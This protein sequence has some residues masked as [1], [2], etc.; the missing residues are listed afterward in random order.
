MQKLRT[1]TRELSA[2]AAPSGSAG[3]MGVFVETMRSNF[4]Q[5]FAN[6][7]VSETV[8]AK[9]GE[10][11]Q[12]FATMAGLARKLAEFDLTIRACSQ[13]AAEA[14]N[15]AGIGSSHVAP[16]PPLQSTPAHAGAR[17]V[18]A[19][20]AAEGVVAI[21]NTS[22]PLTDESRSARTKSVRDS[23]DEELLARGRA[24]RTRRNDDG[25]AWEPDI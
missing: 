2:G 21:A 8:L 9:K 24:V 5:H 18:G 17:S 19:D 13:Q 7:K 14:A 4:Q 25:G 15:S 3:D 22:S 11:E 6:P 12:V 1:E 16:L 10:M 20:A 23:S